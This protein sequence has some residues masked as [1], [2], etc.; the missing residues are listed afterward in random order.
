[1]G[2]RCTEPLCGTQAGAVLD[3]T[4]KL[5]NSAPGEWQTLS[6][7]LSCLTATG[8]DLASV[9]IPFAVETSGR[10]GLTISDVSLAQGT[11]GSASTCAGNLSVVAR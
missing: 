6:I 3:V 2:V 1:M 4:R 10:L 5:K 9:E 11:A 7:P 8:A